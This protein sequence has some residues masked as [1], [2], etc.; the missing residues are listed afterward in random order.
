MAPECLQDEW[1]PLRKDTRITDRE[2][3]RERDTFTFF[4][5]CWV[6]H[7]KRTKNSIKSE[8][9]NPRSVNN[10]FKT[11]IKGIIC[12]GVLI[13]LSLVAFF[14]ISA[15]A[16]HCQCILFVLFIMSTG[17]SDILLIWY[18][19]CCILCS[20]E[21]DIFT[22]K[23]CFCWGFSVMMKELL[24]VSGV[25]L[26]PIVS[27]KDCR[28]KLVAWIFRIMKIC[29]TLLNV[30]TFSLKV[31]KQKCLMSWLYQLYCLY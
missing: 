18:S 24:D 3:E 14:R 2:R 13:C 29:F 30:N 21:G 7:E 6:W 28:L 15:N 22:H 26:P 17:C 27:P 12:V 10:R 9:R 31:K 1:C 8:R 19:E 5:T 11:L 25:V 4:T 23:A 20:R 16:V